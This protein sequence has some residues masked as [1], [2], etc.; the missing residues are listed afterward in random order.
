MP[1]KATKHPIK[2]AGAAEPATS[3]GGLNCQ[4]IFEDT[5]KMRMKW[6]VQLKTWCNRSSPGWGIRARE[7][8]GM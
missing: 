7:N 3:G 6:F 4:P 1:P 8:E 5:E 2:M